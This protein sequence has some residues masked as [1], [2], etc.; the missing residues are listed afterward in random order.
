[1]N[2]IFYDFRDAEEEY[3]K[4]HPNDDFDIKFIKSALNDNTEVDEYDSAETS[5]I[6]I[7]MTSQIT[8]T[9]LDKF[10]NLRIIATRT[11]GYDHI[12]IDECAK[13]N[14]RVL[15][16][17]HYG[18]SSV[19]EFTIGM[20]ITL[21]RNVVPA[22]RDM[23]SENINTQNYIG[24]DLKALKLGVIGTGAIG[25]SVCKVCR[26]FGMEI[27]ANDKQKNPDITGIVEYVDFQT[28]L[29]NAD[30]ITLHIPY[31]K[32]AYHM[33]GDNEFSEMKNGVYLINTARGELVDTAALYNAL[34]KNKIAGCALD[35]Q[36]CENIIV[37]NDENLVS[38]INKTDKNCIQKAVITQKLAES[39]RVIM[40]PHIAYN[41]V[42]AINTILD[43][44]F[45][46]IRD[47]LKGENSTN[48]VV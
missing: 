24:R 3:F 13:R 40:T 27:L 20:M 15:N 10:K 21:I 44:T 6:S 38:I 16:V 37:N 29:K 28:L 33:I 48:R 25:S 36:E 7:F 17:E 31:T 41:T 35:V 4:H 42:D 8:S 45:S 23:R 46:N 22:V 1:M 26:S 2:I 32:E 9:V 30:I 5:I 34:E 11:T 47:S 18:K 19:T 39:D 12:D 43:V 14:I